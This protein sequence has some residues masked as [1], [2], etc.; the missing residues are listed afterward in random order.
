MSIPHRVGLTGGIGSGKSTVASFFQ[1][2]GVPVLDLDLVG[3]E[4]L[5]SN[6]DALMLLVDAFG[7]HFLLPD[8]SLDRTALAR[9]CFSNSAR[10]AQL[11]ALIH[12]LIWK[13]EEAWVAAQHSPFVV[14]EAAVL[15]ES[16][17]AKRMDAV[18]AVLAD[19]ALRLQRVLLRG[20]Q[21]QK[22]FDCVRARQCDDVLRR[23]HAD[24]IIENNGD[25][26]SLKAQ[27]QELFMRLCR[28]V[29][30]DVKKCVKL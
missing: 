10:T 5:S 27:V 28:K 19:E 13:R 17:A 26:K 4:L 29:C 21:D 18:V 22:G 16:G 24:Y 25:M 8:G 3:R 23:E 7:D 1:S 30:E 15:L 9:H 20:G 14:I 12:P 11:N 6:S 2:W